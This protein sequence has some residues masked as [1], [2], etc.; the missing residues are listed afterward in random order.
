MGYPSEEALK[1]DLKFSAI[2]LM[3]DAVNLELNIQ[4]M[5]DLLASK[6]GRIDGELYR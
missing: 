3:A 1:K 2:L 5:C 6:D 4:I